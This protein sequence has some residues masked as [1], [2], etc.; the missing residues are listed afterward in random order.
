MTVK[1]QPTQEEIEYVLTRGVVQVEKEA[2]LRRMLL[3]GNKGEP[4]RIKLGVDPSHY[5]LTIGH[6]VVLR[7]L[8]QFNDWAIKPLLS[9]AIGQRVW[10]I[11]ADEK[12][13]A[14][15]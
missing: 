3:E 4:L 13:L 2:E 14:N 9:S 7:K 6:A 10:V 15:H 5:E 12:R 11:P 8:R 1:Q